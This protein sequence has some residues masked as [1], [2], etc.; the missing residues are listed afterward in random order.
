MSNLNEKD[1][2]DRFSNMPFEHRIQI[3]HGKLLTVDRY[4]GSHESLPLFA[5]LVGIET[6]KIIL[7]KMNNSKNKIKNEQNLKQKF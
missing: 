3:G 5:H 2:S 7:V 1:S 6:E 4:S